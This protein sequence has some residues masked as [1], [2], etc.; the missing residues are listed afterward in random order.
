MIGC[1]VAALF[2]VLIAAEMIR[3]NRLSDN[4]LLLDEHVAHLD[5]HSSKI[6]MDLTSEPVGEYG[7]TTLMVTHNVQIASQYGNRVLVLKDRKIAF[8]KKYEQSS[9]RSPHELLSL[10]S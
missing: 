7:L 8:D 10:I 2:T 9:E 3:S 1:G 6:V 4:L 5:P